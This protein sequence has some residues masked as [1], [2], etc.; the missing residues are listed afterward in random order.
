MT[1]LA[2]DAAPPSEAVGPLIRGLAVLRELAAARGL[3]GAGDLV[4]ATS[5]ARS[6]V[7]RTLGTLERLGYL[8]LEGRTAVP[9]PRLMELG[10]AYLS[11]CGLPDL[12]GPLADGLADELDESV[13][14]AVPDRDGVRFVYQ[15][16]RRR[17]MSVAFRIGD[18]LP[19][20]CGAPGAL[21]AAG[22]TEAEWE[23]WRSRRRADPHLAAFPAVP[24][25]AAGAGD[26]FP[27]RV[28]AARRQ[29]W[30]G[31]D[32]LI[33]PGLVA[34]AVPVRDAGGRQVCAASVVSHTSRHSAGSL[35][36]TLLPR[37]RQAVARMERAL[38]A[39]PAPP[40]PSG[41]KA[42]G[43]AEDVPAAAARASKQELGPGFVESLARGL[44][45]L[46]AFGRGRGGA[47]L[48]ALAEAT[49]LPRATVRRSLITLEHLGYVTGEGPLFRPAPRVLELGFARLSGLTLPQIAQPHL[50]SLVE[51]VHDSASMSVLAGDEIRYVARVPT[52]R[53]MSVDITVGTRFPAHATSMGRVLLAGL[54]AAERAERLR[55][56]DLRPLT[57]STVTCAERLGEIV[58]RAAHD[59][60]ALVEEELEEGL[61]SL[62][63]P[64]RD[65]AGRTVA[66]VNVSMHTSRRS[67][68][69][70]R[71]E[72]LPELRRT[73]AD[74]EADLRV[75]GRHTAIRTA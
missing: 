55:R 5:L 57:R 70:A 43:R 64:V 2:T 36:E 18:L 19:A 26:T 24:P 25:E 71:A 68:E 46:A 35:R 6:T 11:A 52:V 40:A 17:T 3:P 37:L 16:R 23:R 50:A 74:I 53:I 66:A 67:A 51:R 21:F 39:P 28:A 27:G 72:L 14:L 15:A 10:N 42:P 48:T 22:W 4:R 34:V 54:P 7:D 33:E 12:L 59:G 31:D 45:V 41:W 30:S 32:Q 8:R 65:R 20:E 62:A 47:T 38:A 61:R 60:Y 29:G 63:V 13:S 56:A 69:Q 58:A 49:G 9:A 1:N 73:A 75:A 44:A